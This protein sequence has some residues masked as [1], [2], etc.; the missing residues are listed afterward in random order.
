MTPTS[1][2]LHG[3]EKKLARLGAALL[4]AITALQGC[5]GGPPP[6]SE[7]EV[8]PRVTGILSTIASQR[9]DDSLIGLWNA[10][11]AGFSWSVAI[12]KEENLSRGYTLKGLMIKPWSSFAEG[13][14]VLYL[15]RSSV[16]GVYEGTQK[17]KD[18][19]G[20]SS[21]SPARVVAQGE[22]LFTQY[23]SVRSHPFISTTWVYL[24]KLRPWRKR[25]ERQAEGG[26]GFCC[27]ALPSC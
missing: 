6:S 22:N 16:P 11:S 7:G 5:A 19:L 18:A 26:P 12:I 13:E 21:W 24:R 27:A 9:G 15:K 10:T 1:P 23:N 3:R 8:S 14:E 20:F 4:L 25:L 2:D 17:W